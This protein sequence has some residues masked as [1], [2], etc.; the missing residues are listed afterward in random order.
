[1]KGINQANGEYYTMGGW[2]QIIPSLADH[3]DKTY[4]MTTIQ[5]STQNRVANLSKFDDSKKLSFIHAK[6]TPLRRIL[7]FW[8]VGNLNL[9][10]MLQNKV[11]VVLIAIPTAMPYLE[12][13]GG[14]AVEVG[15]VDG[16]VNY[17]QR[18]LHDETLRK[19]MGGN[20]KEYAVRMYDSDKWVK[21]MYEIIKS[22][23]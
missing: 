22:I 15:D 12:G 18:L 11:D 6:N 10:R 1:M 2:P 17:C 13:K 9:F 7:P 4:L 16:M 8:S 19:R 23:L 5:I 14:F 20:T 3:F 21:R